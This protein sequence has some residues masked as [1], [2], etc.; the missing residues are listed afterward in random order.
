MG[1]EKERQNGRK[2]GY[3]HSSVATLLWFFFSFCK[4]NVHTYSHTKRG[5]RP[6]KRDEKEEKR[7][8]FSFC[9]SLSPAKRYVH[10]YTHLTWRNICAD[11]GNEKEMKKWRKRRDYTPSAPLS[12]GFSLSSA[13]ERVHL[14]AHQK[15]R[16][17]CAYMVDEKKGAEGAKRRMFFPHTKRGRRPCEKEKELRRY[18]LFALLF[19]FLCFAFLCSFFVFLLDLKKWER[20]RGKE[21]DC[22]Y[23]CCSPRH[24]RTI[25]K[26]GF[27]K[28]MERRGL[29]FHGEKGKLKRDERESSAFQNPQRNRLCSVWLAR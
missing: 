16:H 17:M 7:R 25:E 20:G 3:L 12:F 22:H 13:K 10:L 11:M 23:Y 24:Q 19:V 6:R 26:R 21:E 18:P 1:T 15:G 4:N 14:Y 9:S 5:R 27:K 28:R 8:L 29:S 2:S